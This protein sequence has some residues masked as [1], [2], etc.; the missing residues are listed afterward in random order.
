MNWEWDNTLE[1]I[2]PGTTCP[3]SRHDAGDSTGKLGD[4]AYDVLEIYPYLYIGIYNG[5]EEIIYF[6]TSVIY[7][8]LS[9]YLF[10]RGFSEY[11]RSTDG[12]I[13]F[14]VMSTCGSDYCIAGDQEYRDADYGAYAGIS[15]ACDSILYDL[16]CGSRFWLIRFRIL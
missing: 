15:Q 8:L 16:H 6:H 12:R 10:F 7:S 14:P 4:G 11:R 9:H 5:V 3:Y 2:L 1:E 13:S